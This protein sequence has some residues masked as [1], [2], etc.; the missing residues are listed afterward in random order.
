MNRT[1]VTARAHR[2]STAHTNSVVI[3]FS[4]R[5][6]IKPM[7]GGGGKKSSSVPA[8]TAGFQEWA[9]SII[10]GLGWVG[11]VDKSHSFRPSY[12]RR[13]VTGGTALARRVAGVHFCSVLC[14]IYLSPS[15]PVCQAA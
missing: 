12:G 15:T 7:A 11:R 8:A 5:K 4:G 6:G 2:S 14:S 3:L 13:L 1:P 10:D 9:A